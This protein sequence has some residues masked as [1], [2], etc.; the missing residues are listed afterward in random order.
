MFRAAL[1]AVFSSNFASPRS[2]LIGCYLL[3]RY[4]GKRH[5]QALFA[6]ARR[7]VL[8]LQAMICNTTIY[9]PRPAS[10]PAATA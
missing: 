5:N 2:D 6:L 10:Q 8:T 3:K 1:K 9:D 7:R 4:Q